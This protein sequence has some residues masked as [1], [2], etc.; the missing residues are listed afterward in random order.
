LP[1]PARRCTRQSGQ[2]GFR[3]QPATHKR[4]DCQ[5]TPRFA[6]ARSIATL[7]CLS[8]SLLQPTVSVR[9]RTLGGGASTSYL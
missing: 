8:R 3:L 7:W 2:H 4:L 5:S 9:I 6:Q 1:P